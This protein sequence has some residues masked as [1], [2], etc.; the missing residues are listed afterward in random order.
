MC[1]GSGLQLSFFLAIFREIA[2]GT[3]RIVVPFYLF[4]SWFKRPR[5]NSSDYLQEPLMPQ[6]PCGFDVPGRIVIFIENFLDIF[7]RAHSKAVVIAKSAAIV[8]RG[9]RV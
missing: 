5:F 2:Y 9:L 6:L 4:V 7:G 8:M 1:C 3:V